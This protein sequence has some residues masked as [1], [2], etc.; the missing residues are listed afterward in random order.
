MGTTITEITGDASEAGN[1][2]KVLSMRLRGAS[3]EIEQIGESTDGMAE[4]TSKL[5]EKILALT[6]VTGKGVFDIMADADNFKSTYQILDELAAKWQDLTDIQQASITELIA[7]KRQG[8]IVS[9]LMSN[10]DTARRATETA[11][12]STGSALKEQEE[13]EKGIEY[14]L[15]R[16][17][18][19]FQEFA[20]HILDSSFIKGIVDFGNS[21]INVIDKITSKLGSLGTI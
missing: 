13:Y 10:F 16:L 6:N 2:L 4:S 14:S 20:N 9:A 19:S 11:V 7:G 18:A 3:T 15:K 1:T 17:E 8:N 12:N 21:A 5:R